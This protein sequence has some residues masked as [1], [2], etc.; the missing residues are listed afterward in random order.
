MIYVTDRIGYVRKQYWP[1]CKTESLGKLIMRT[2]ASSVSLFMKK[3]SSSGGEVGGCSL[4]IFWMVRGERTGEFL[5]IFI[6]FHFSDLRPPR[7]SGFSPGL[8]TGEE[9]VVNF[10]Y[11]IWHFK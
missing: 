10:K 8:Y 5:S 3:I 11:F 1:Q 7:A 2:N 6:I 9:E 4:F